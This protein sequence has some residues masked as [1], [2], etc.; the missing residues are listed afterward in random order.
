MA[1]EIPSLDEQL[2][3]VTEIHGSIDAY[4]NHFCTLAADRRRYELWVFNRSFDEEKARP[5]KDYAAH[6]QLRRELT[7]LDTMLKN[8]GR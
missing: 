6:V 3:V 4:K 2:A 5:T 1:E 7:G 8:S